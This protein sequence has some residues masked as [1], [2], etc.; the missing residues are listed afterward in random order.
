MVIVTL[1]LPKARQLGIRLK[2]DMHYQRKLAENMNT[3]S[4]YSKVAIYYAPWEL[5]DWLRSNTERG[6]E[7]ECYD[8]LVAETLRI[9]AQRNTRERLVNGIGCAEIVA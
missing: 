5:T 2:K 1:C 3:N 4:L 6:L 7:N 9:V 8:I